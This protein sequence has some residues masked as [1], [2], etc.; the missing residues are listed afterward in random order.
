MFSEEL[1][2]KSSE[3]SVVQSDWLP[4]C[5][6]ETSNDTSAA[7]DFSGQKKI[8]MINDCAPIAVSRHKIQAWRVAIW[9]HFRS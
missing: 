6:M 3:G 8:I 4:K 2:Q 7:K 1:H 5:H 9:L